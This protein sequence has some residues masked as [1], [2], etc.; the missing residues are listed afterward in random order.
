MTQPI[1]ALEAA[2]YILS[3]D[4]P[5]AGDLMSNLKLQKL[6]YYGQ[7]VHLALHDAPLFEEEIQAW[8]HGPVCPAVYRE[9]KKYGSGPIPKPEAFESNTLPDEA[10][11]V[12]KEVHTVFGQFSAWRLREMTHEEAPWKEYYKEGEAKITIPRSALMRHFA[13]VVEKG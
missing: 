3:L 12:L 7:G 2:K 1:K 11:E 6:L 8:L 10:Q 9:F 5:E 13:T 4:D